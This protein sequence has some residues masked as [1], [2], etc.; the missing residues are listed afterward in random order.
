MN[1]DL[2]ASVH[3]AIAAGDYTQALDLWNRYIASLDAGGLTAESLEGVRALVS[4][5]RPALLGAREHAR[6]RLRV[7]R[8]AGVYNSSPSSRRS[9]V[10]TSL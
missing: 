10:R 4:W 1:S 3:R 6:K 2:A 8:V 9:L 7:L 5:C